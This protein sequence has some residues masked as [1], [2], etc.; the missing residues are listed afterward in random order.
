MDFYESKSTLATAHNDL[1]M[2]H[3]KLDRILTLVTQ[4]VDAAATY[5]QPP[6]DIA[7]KG[8]AEPISELCTK[9]SLGINDC[10]VA[11]REFDRTL[12]G[13]MKAEGM[14]PDAIKRN[15]GEILRRL[16]DEDGPGGLSF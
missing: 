9:V 12:L 11:F 6:E 5:G 3:A 1:D 16:S 8:V 7:P 4:T 10:L 14:D 2:L 15:L 13:M